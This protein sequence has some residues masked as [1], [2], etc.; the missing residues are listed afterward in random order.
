MLIVK[1]IIFTRTVVLPL[2]PSEIVGRILD[3]S[4]W[5]NFTGFGP[6]PGVRSAVFEILTPGLVGSRIRVTNMDDS[7]H[8]H[9]IIEW[10]PDRLLKM[11]MTDFTAPLSRFATR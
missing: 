6:L 4:L 3:P 8:V 1:P 9:E 10:N 5:S 11:N 2:T 7:T